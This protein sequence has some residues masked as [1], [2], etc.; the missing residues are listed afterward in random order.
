[1]VLD[2]LDEERKRPLRATAVSCRGDIVKGGGAGDGSRTHTTLRSADFESAA[3]AI[4]PLRPEVG[5][6]AILGGDPSGCQP[7]RH[8]WCVFWSLVDGGLAFGV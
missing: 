3:S 8:L 4:P 7:V 1:M 6:G 5:T 2:R